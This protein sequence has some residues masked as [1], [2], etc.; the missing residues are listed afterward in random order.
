MSDR[1]D[2]LCSG[3]LPGLKIPGKFHLSQK[4]KGRFPKRT[5]FGYQVEYVAS[6]IPDVK[7]EKGGDR[8]T[9]GLP[10]TELEDDRRR[11]GDLPVEGETYK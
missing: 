3:Y 5:G 2:I 8:K 6:Q 7:L 9:S 4:K 1:A 10:C 11:Q